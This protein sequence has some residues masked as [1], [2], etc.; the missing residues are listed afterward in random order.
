MSEGNVAS[1][2]KEKEPTAYLLRRNFATHMSI[3]GLTN[4]EMQYLMG[5][6]VEDAYESRNEFVDSE[7]IFIMH[8][9]LSNRPLLNTRTSN[10]NTDR[11]CIHKQS[12]VRIHASALEPSDAVSIRIEAKDPEMVQTKCFE[13]VHPGVYARTVNNLEQY[14]AGYKSSSERNNPHVRYS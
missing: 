6:N 12:T 2:L 5:H 9:K 3:L 7:R 8:R 14:S 11:I 4:A 10:D 1:I 13:S